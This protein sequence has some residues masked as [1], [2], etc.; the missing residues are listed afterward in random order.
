MKKVVITKSIKMPACCDVCLFSDW[1]NLH[2]TAACKLQAWEPCFCDHSREFK[3]KR[4]DFCP[5]IE[6]D[7]D[8]IVSRKGLLEEYDRQ[9]VG[10]P[11][12]ARKIIE[13]VPSAIEGEKA[14]SQSIYLE[15]TESRL[16]DLIKD[17]TKDPEFTKSYLQAYKNIIATGCC[18]ECADRKTCSKRP[19]WGQLVRYNCMFFERENNV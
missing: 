12:G 7:A 14:D 19:E 6:V 15:K 3:H 9:H 10:P 11:G 17:P 1:S 5:L 2:Q 18:N 4:A 8:D 13:K 16:D